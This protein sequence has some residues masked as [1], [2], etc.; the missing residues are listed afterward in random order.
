VA[1]STTVESGG[2]LVVEAGGSAL[3]V[4][5][6]PG[7]RLDV[8]VDVRYLTKITGSNASG[9]F[10]LSAQKADNFVLCEGAEMIVAVGEANSTT[11]E[12]GGSQTVKPEGLANFTTV[13]SGGI[14]VVEDGGSALDIVQR[15]GGRLRVTMGVRSRTRVT[16]SNASGG[17]ALSA[18]KADNFVLYEGAELI[19][20]CGES[21]STTIEA[22]G[23]QIIDSKGRDSFAVIRSGGEM[24]VSRGGTADSAVVSSGGVLRVFSG[25]RVAGAVVHPF[26][27]LIVRSGGVAESTVDSGG[28]IQMPGKSA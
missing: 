7:G 26:G 16:G 12:A 17:F 18:Q 13:R 8:V 10:A 14:L 22:G 11:I 28:T 6:R 25:G 15:P 1:Q 20:S 27:Q 2:L 21:N 19:V 24:L 5:Q 9:G 3:D 4:V 23:R